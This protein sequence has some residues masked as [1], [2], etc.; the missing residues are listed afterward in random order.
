MITEW[1][2][3]KVVNL[4]TIAMQSF[5]PSCVQHLILATRKKGWSTVLKSERHKL[6]EIED[7]QI[8]M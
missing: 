1:L 5:L 3:K 8:Y 6:F 2:L 4:L 7:A